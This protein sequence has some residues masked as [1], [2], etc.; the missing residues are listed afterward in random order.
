VSDRRS[1]YETFLIYLANRFNCAYYLLLI[2]GKWSGGETSGW[3]TL[4]GVWWKRA[5]LSGSG[6]SR[7]GSDTAVEN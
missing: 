4:L 2:A 6:S 5:K 7:S 3:L 1:C